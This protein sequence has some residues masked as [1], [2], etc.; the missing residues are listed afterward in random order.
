[1]GL[2]ARLP[3]LLPEHR[4]RM[5]AEMQTIT[6][7]QLMDMSAGFPPDGVAPFTTIHDVFRAPD[8]TR[9]VLERGLVNPPGAV[10]DYS[11]SASHLVTAALAAALR[12]ADGPRP[13]SVLAYA[14]ERL[15][16][17]LQIDT[18]DAFSAPVELPTTTAYE[19]GGFGWGTDKLGVHSGC[20]LL[21]LRAADMVKLGELYLGNGEWRGRRILPAAW[22]QESL[23][24]SAMSSGY[25]LMWWLQIS[26]SGQPAFSAS[27]HGGQLIAV[28]PE[29]QAVVVIASV[30][31]GETTMTPDDAWAFVSATIFPA[32]G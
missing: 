17:P 15:F 2:D 11:S 8:A 10:F 1:M 27:G 7:R 28:F 19:R 13:R 14:R 31:D 32:L 3:E 21:R 18:T 20:C 16:T 12:R 25:G 4:A 29:R 6:L 23:R 30:D 9:F 24:P 5:T 26:P 22:V